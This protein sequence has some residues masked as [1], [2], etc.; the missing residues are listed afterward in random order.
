MRPRYSHMDILL[1]VY[2]HPALTVLIDDSQTFLD[3]LAFQ[4]DPHV[5]RKIFHDTQK[6]LAWLKQTHRQSANRNL[7]ICVDYDEET[8]SFERRTIAVDVDQIYRQ[9]MNPQRFFMPSVLVIDYAMPQMNG[10]AFCQQ[11]E[12]LP[13]KKIL[14]TGQADEKIAID[15]FNRGLIDRFIK[16]SDPEALDNLETE[17]HG[18][19]KAFFLDQSRTL[20]ELLARHSY[21][22]LSDPAIG[23]L[24]EQL[25]NRYGFVEYYLFP[26]PTGILFFD[27]NGKPTLMVVETEGSLLSHFEIAL[28]MGGTPELLSALRERRIVPFFHEKG[29]RYS[30][31][32]NDWLSYCLPA[33]LCTGRQNYF[34]AL[35]D[36]P[37]HYL[38][39]PVYSYAE[40]LR[41]QRTDITS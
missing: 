11:I 15:A 2:Q 26:N 9:V 29:S 10:V 8:L 20:K 3:S 40:F 23:A 30:E 36:L 18:L 24:A 17:I 7:P 31:S 35:F 1:P 32:I 12:D 6:A 38:P 25:C 41:E 5:A 33:Q 27:I 37:S 39:G 19:Q 13:C 34:W 22:F 21:T 4:L 28:D 16:K 14:F